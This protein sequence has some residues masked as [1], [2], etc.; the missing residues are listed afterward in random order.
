MRV[1]AGCASRPKGEDVI[2]T[3]EEDHFSAMV[4]AD[5]SS[6]VEWNGREISGG[7]REAAQIAARTA[8]TYL[9]GHLLPGMGIEEMVAILQGCFRQARTALEKHNASTTT[10]GGTTLLIALLCQG[11]DGLWY[12]L[13]GNLGN[14][15]LTLLHTQPLFAR[16]PIHTPLLSNHANG[17]TTI[18]LPGYATQ[19]YLPSVGVRP[20]S[21]G[22]M[23]VIGSDGLD[24]LNS[25]TM[26]CDRLYFLNFL[27]TQIQQGRSCLDSCLQA[28]PTGRTD[29]PWQNALDLDDTTIGILWA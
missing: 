1:G 21:P 13:Y 6:S 8:L 7:G 18:S 27:W 11:G 29:A 3:A 12:W 22:D 4:V 23:L 5:G 9:T 20:H 26:K 14:G 19:G 17:V 24:H 15:V 2:M 10:P 28:L 16:W 25:V